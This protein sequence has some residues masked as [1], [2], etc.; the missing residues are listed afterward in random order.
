[1]AKYSFSREH[2]DAIHSNPDTFNIDHIGE[3]EKLAMTIKTA[4]P[5]KRFKVICSDVHCDIITE[6]EW[7]V[8]EQTTLANII[9]AHKAV[10]DW[11]MIE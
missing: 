3:P 10:D 11:P 7:T 6:E 4:F 8:E 9:V 2:G 5:G 1:M